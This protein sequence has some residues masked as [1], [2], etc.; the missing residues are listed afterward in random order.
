MIK[1]CQDNKEMLQF[2][3]PTNQQQYD[4]RLLSAAARGIVIGVLK[5]EID[6]THNIFITSA[7]PV[8]GAQAIAVDYR[9]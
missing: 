9:N 6:D 3:Q 1:H 5:K 4:Q 2:G 7:K 8:I